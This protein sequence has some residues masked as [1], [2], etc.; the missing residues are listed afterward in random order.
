MQLA[1]DR[2]AAAIQ[3]KEMYGRDP[4][5]YIDE[6]WMSDQVSAIETDDEEKAAEYLSRL[7][8]KA[9]FSAQDI[10]EERPVWEVIRKGFRSALVSRFKVKRLTSC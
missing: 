1:Q 6:A 7:Q 5:P 2:Q 8:A 4:T 3:Y 9:G 10:A